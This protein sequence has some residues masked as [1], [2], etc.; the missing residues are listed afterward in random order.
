MQLKIESYESLF[1]DC[2]RD[3]K[4]CEKEIIQNER[5]IEERRQTIKDV[6]AKR[7]E[8]IGLREFLKKIINPPDSK[9]ESLSDENV[10]EK[11]IDFQ[12]ENSE[13]FF[14]VETSKGLIEIP[15][16]SFKR[17]DTIKEATIHL[18]RIVK[19]PL[20]HPQIAD[21]LLKGGFE[22]KSVVAFSE[23]VRSTLRSAS[24]SLR[25]EI[26]RKNRSWHLKEWSSDSSNSSSKPA[27]TNKSSKRG[28]HLLK[29]SKSAGD[30]AEDVLRIEGKELHI[31]EI[32]KRLAEDGINPTLGSLDAAMR[33]DKRKRFEKVR[34]QTYRLVNKN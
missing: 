25:S 20:K 17:F 34:P 15:L 13:S 19:S 11:Q 24:K 21:A 6:D 12:S 22:T 33:Q 9:N 27:E 10:L 31:D 32:H 14:T 28:I 2:E 5:E 16:D 7:Q 26:I 29:W 30:A 3:I 18:L 4:E 8:L 23:N 1:Q